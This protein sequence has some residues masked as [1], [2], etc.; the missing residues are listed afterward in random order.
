[1]QISSKESTSVELQKHD[2]HPSD[3]LVHFAG[4]HLI[5]DLWDAKNLN[6]PDIIESSL[7][8]A[9]VACDTT[10]LNLYVHQFEPAG[11]TGVALLAESHISVHTW[12]ERKY[13]AFDLFTCG[14]G[15]PYQ[16]VAVLK[17]AFHPGHLQITEQKRGL[18]LQGS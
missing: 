13:A 5:I 17:Q 10:L 6:N 18:A 4:V 15:N 9:A 1:M 7:R 16:A 3:D 2:F 8:A 14:T 12:P 11:I